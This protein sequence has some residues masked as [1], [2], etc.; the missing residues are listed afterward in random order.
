MEEEEHRQ[1]V[2]EKQKSQQ[3]QTVQAAPEQP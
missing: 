3:D 1:M 2:I